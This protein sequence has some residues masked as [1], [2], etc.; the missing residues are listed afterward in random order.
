MSTESLNIWMRRLSASP[1]DSRR[2]RISIRMRHRVGVG[3]AVFI[4]LASAPASAGA[5]IIPGRGVAGLKLGA[6]TAQVRAIL[7]KPATLQHN[8]GGEQN[9]LYDKN[10]VDWV[11]LVAKGSRTTVEGIETSDK[12]QKTPQGVGPGSSMAALK[13]AYPHLTCKKGWLGV[14]FTSCWILTSVAA[15]RIPTNFVLFKRKVDTVD[16]GQIGERNL[17][18]QS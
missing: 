18:P 15:H 8:S 4:F 16:I 12:T 13:K 1:H 7:G 6:S 3:A 17:A 11:T 9:W 14:P 10:P 5:A 2:T